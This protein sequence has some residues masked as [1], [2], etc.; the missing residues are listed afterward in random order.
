MGRHLFKDAHI[1]PQKSGDMVEEFTCRRPVCVTP[2]TLGVR[3]RGGKN[4]NCRMLH[5]VSPPVAFVRCCWCSSRLIAGN[6]AGVHHAQ[7]VAHEEPVGAT[8]SALTTPAATGLHLVR[9]SA[10]PSARE[11]SQAD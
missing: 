4:Q 2:C 9:L 7:Q 10:L 5:R 3:Q 11:S 1:E 8:F 6:S